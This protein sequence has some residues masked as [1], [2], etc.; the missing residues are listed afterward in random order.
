[1]VD[2]IT[3]LRVCRPKMR[4]HIPDDCMPLIVYPA[5]ALALVLLIVLIAEWL[6]L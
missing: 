3:E 6:S 5:V 1:M 2:L 4:R